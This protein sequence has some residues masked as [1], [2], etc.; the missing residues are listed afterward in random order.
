[1]KFRSLSVILQRNENRK[2]REKRKQED[3]VER[4]EGGEGEGEERLSS[5]SRGCAMRAK[6]LQILWHGDDVKDCKPVLG[7]D[8]SVEDNLVAT[9]GAD[10]E[11]KL[12]HHEMCAR[13]R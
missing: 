3:A 13:R 8:V 12:R 10:N 6:A 1:M 2:E 9:A 4:G 11:I 5:R 7:V